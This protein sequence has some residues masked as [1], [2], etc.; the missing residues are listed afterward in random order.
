MANTTTPLILTLLI[1]FIFR[2]YHNKISVKR[3][4][5]EAKPN[6]GVVT[7][8]TKTFSEVTNG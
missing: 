5:L 8:N 7:K 6:I 1:K 2:Q 3:R 4:I